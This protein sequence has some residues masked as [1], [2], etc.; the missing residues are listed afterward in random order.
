[1]SAVAAAPSA[2]LLSAQWFRV[3]ALRPRVDRQARVERQVVRTQV[4]HLLTRADGSA[5]FRMNAPA[6]SAVARCTGRLTVQQAWDCALAEHGDDAPTQDEF[7]DMLARLQAAGLMSFDK[8]PDFGAQ[9]VAADPRPAEPADGAARS[10]DRKS[11][12]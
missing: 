3:A 2:P 10:R 5:T 9:R 8:R 11:V 1:M 7:I 12:V 4:W 6:W